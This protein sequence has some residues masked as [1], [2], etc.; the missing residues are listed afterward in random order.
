MN[1]NEQNNLNSFRSDL[2]EQRRLRAQNVAESK[3][4]IEHSN[5]LRVELEIEYN[6]AEELKQKCLDRIHVAEF[7]TNGC[8][9]DEMIDQIPMLITIQEIAEFTQDFAFAPDCNDNVVVRL[10]WDISN[11][12]IFNANRYM[13]SAFQNR[14]HFGE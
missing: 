3:K 1:T 14:I 13:N 12:D 9:I 11:L 5:R 4:L 6:K 10:D 8:S 7:L 2:E